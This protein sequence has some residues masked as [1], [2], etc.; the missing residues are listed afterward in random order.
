MTEFK[1]EQLGRGG[2]PFITKISEGPGGKS[3]TFHGRP[4]GVTYISEPKNNAE[5]MVKY[6]G[7][8]D[9]SYE[10]EFKDGT[11]ITGDGNK[12]TVVKPK[13]RETEQKNTKTDKD[14]NS[15]TTFENDK[16]HRRQETK[17]G[18]NEEDL[19]SETLFDKN[20]PEKLEKLRDFTDRTEKSFQNGVKVTEFKP[21]QLGRGGDPFITKISEGPGGKSTT[22]HGRPDG[23][24]YISEPKNNAEGMVKYTGKKDGSYEKE[25]KDG[26]IIT[27]DGNK[28]TVVKPKV[29]E[30]EQKN[31]KTD[32]DGNS[33][34]TFENDKQHRR[35]ETKFGRNEEDLR[36]ETLFDKNH[37]E[38]LEK[39]RDFTDRTEKSFQNG[40]KVT[41]FKP[42]QLGRGGDPFITKI[43]EGPRGKFTTFQ[44]RPDGVT[45][46]SE[47]KNNAEGMVKYT[48]KKDGSYEKE[49]KDGTIIKG[50]GNKEETVVK[51]KRK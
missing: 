42:E 25:F 34:T 14:G 45:Y 36:S 39:L 40:A 20:H 2:D 26:T 7:K 38:K 1:P 6:T 41:E 13:V 15:V 10:K 33:V 5:G 31:T 11:I 30:T 27:G 17:F 47:P 32:K 49:F 43:S 28:E 50:D 37:P 8:K 29:R 19:R 23:V 44:G 3:T 16:Q 9:G 22:F 18:R 48:G 12:E 21:E 51:P 24:T 4:D 46:I 35:Q